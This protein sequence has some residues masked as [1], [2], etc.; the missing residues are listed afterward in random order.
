M[1]TRP[2]HELLPV[3]DDRRERRGQHE[4]DDDAQRRSSRRGPTYGRA[5]VNGSTP[6]IEN[7]MTYL[8]PNRSPSGPPAKVPTATAA[9]NTKRCS[10]ALRT[11]TSKRSHQIERVVA[12]EARQVDELREDEREQHGERRRRLAASR[13]RP[14]PRASAAA[15]LRRE[16][17]E[18]VALVPEAHARRG[19]TVETS[20]S[21]ETG[22]EPRCPQRRRRWPRPAGPARN[23]RCRRPGR[24]TARSPGRP[25]EAMRATRDDSG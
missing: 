19:C 18:A 16:A 11:E 12:R 1:P 4:A 2:G 25:P 17:R 23:R 9:R 8:R 14:R 5:S 22:P 6:R 13:E 21:S 20:A 24:A 7:Q 15:R 3:D 10:C